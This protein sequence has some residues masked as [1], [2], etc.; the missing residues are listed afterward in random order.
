MVP[1][2]AH[3]VYSEITCHRSS[4]MILGLKAAS[5]DQMAQQGRE[6]P[7]SLGC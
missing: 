2:H 1:V 5:N 3:I 7:T 4:H 6:N